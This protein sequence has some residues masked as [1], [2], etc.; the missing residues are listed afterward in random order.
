M[1]QG[2]SHK[3]IV[4]RSDRV[5]NLDRCTWPA[6][7]VADRVTMWSQTLHWIF[8]SHV[9]SCCFISPGVTNYGR[10]SIVITKERGVLSG[11][12]AFDV[13]FCL[14]V[15]LDATNVSVK[16]QAMDFLAS[17]C[18]HNQEGHQKAIDVFERYK[19]RSPHN[20]TQ[21]ISTMRHST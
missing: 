19:V 14:F 1:V 12:R 7:W 5:W 20:D 3:T 15:A 13:V 4:N 2:M 11:W 17:L 6:T 9:F 8:L 21:Q 10:V 16:K 18:E